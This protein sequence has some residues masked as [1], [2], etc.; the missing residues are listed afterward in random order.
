MHRRRV[1]GDRITYVGL[2]VHKEGI[3][4]ALAEEGIRGEARK[5][6]RIAN[7]A[8]A[9]DRVAR[10]LGCEGL[11]LRFCYEDLPDTEHR[12]EP[13]EAVGRPHHCSSVSRVHLGPPVSTAAIKLHYDSVRRTASAS[14]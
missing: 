5:Y 3:V 1:V 8:T 11:R 6:G 7:T 4:V 14:S 10:K 12:D 13:A 2:D 9:L